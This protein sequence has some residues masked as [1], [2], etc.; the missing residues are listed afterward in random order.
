MHFKSTEFPFFF[1]GPDLLHFW[2]GL[3][4]SEA[5][6]ATETSLTTEVPRATSILRNLINPTENNA[7]STATHWYSSHVGIGG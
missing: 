5:N 4:P 1:G 2:P 3:E 6:H 7:R